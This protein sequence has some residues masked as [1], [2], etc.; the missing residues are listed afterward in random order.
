MVILSHCPKGRRASEI[1]AL[2]LTPRSAR[3]EPKKIKMLAHT[4]VLS[5]P[6]APVQHPKNPPS[7]IPW[8]S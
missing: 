7:L 5:P 3:K 2:H 8:V 1:T 4:K 6:H